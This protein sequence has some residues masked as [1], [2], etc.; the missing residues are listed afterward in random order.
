M[1]A[2]KIQIYWRCLFCGCVGFDVPEDSDIA[3]ILQVI[4]KRHVEILKAAART[5]EKPDL[6]IHVHG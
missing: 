4:G 5:C 6:W 2:V 1:T 3:K